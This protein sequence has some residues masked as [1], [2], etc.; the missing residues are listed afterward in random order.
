VAVPV[1]AKPFTQLLVN[2]HKLRAIVLAAVCFFPRTIQGSFNKGL[3]HQRYKMRRALYEVAA[4]AGSTKPAALIALPKG[5]HR[6]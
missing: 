4:D 5:F 3:H 6:R 2:K 1:W